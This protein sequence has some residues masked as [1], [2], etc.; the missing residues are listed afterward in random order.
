[1]NDPAGEFVLNFW[2]GVIATVAVFWTGYFFGQL[3][4][5]QRYAMQHPGK[6]DEPQ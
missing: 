6:S 2:L 3:Y 1:M 5:W 4:A